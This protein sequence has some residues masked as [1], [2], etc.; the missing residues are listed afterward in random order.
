MNAAWDRA[1]PDTIHDSAGRRLMASMR[2][3]TMLTTPPWAQD[4]GTDIDLAALMVAVESSQSPVALDLPAGHQ[5][6]TNL[7]RGCW[8]LERH[9][10]QTVLRAGEDPVESWPSNRRKQWRRAERAGM[11]AE[12]TQDVPLMTA[13]HQAARQRKAIKSDGSALGRLLTALMQ[14]QD[15]HAWIVRGREGDVLV[16]GVFHGDGSGRCIYGFGGQFRGST[17]ESTSLATV[18]LIGHAMRHAVEQGNTIFDFGGSMDAGVD[19]FY[20]EFGAGKVPKT[21][22]VRITAPLKWLYRFGRPDLFPR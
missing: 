2:L 16:G 10:R 17:Q 11:T 8:T 13:L 22:V 9:T 6:L 19:R 14:E 7:P 1:F 20:A 5:P 4:I 15:T 21:R 18:F 12:R 3:G